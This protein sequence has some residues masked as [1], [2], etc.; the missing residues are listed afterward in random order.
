MTKQEMIAAL[1]AATDKATPEVGTW[2]IRSGNGYVQLVWTCDEG[3]DGASDMYGD[4]PWSKWGGNE[5]V[6][7][8]AMPSPDDSGC[9]GYTDEYGDAMICQWSEWKVE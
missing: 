2:L 4:E 7:S 6:E 1:T 5:I 9:D 3:D 8:A